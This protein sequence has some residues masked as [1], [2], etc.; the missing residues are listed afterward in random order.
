M[1]RTEGYL[2]H[3]SSYF[4]GFRSDTMLMAVMINKKLISILSF[5]LPFCN[6]VG[7]EN[8]SIVNISVVISSLSK[9]SAS[10]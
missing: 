7:L 3:L 6:N 10:M 8:L 4:P 2:G 5:T 9:H 1:D